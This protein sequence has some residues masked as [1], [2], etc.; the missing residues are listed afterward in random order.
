MKIIFK[1]NHF[2]VLFLS[3][4]LLSCSSDSSNED[5]SNG[6]EI[7]NFTINQQEFGYAEFQYSSVGGAI[8]YEVFYDYSS[9]NSIPSTGSNLTFHHSNT[10]VKYLNDSDFHINTEVLYSFYI[11]AVNAQGQ[12]SQWY[13]PVVYSFEPF[14]EIVPEELYFNNWTGLKWQYSFY[15]SPSYFQIEYGTQGF[16]VGAGVGTVVTSNNN[17]TENITLI[18]GQ[19]YDFYVR[20]WCSSSLG[21]SRWSEPLSYFAE[22][23]YNQC[24][25]PHNVQY[26][27]VRNSSNQAVGANFTWGDLGGNN[28]Y[29]YNLVSP[30]QPPTYGN[31]EFG[32]S[33]TVT[34][35][36]MYQNMDYH[37]YVRTVCSNGTKTDWTGPI[38]VNIGY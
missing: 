13:G 7:T 19:Y 11:R 5:N 3:F 35:I 32:T 29:E 23:G 6:L 21:W 34:Y 4:A 14:C 26:T 33:Q 38:L 25:T 24:V 1:K 22:T 20:S 28:N 9:N 36:S 12:Y 8:Y 17:F 31:I 2:F 18:Q 10:T 37:F 16:P 27:V 15:D 30:S